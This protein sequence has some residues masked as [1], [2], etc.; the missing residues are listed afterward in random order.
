[1]SL[2]VGQLRGEL[3]PLD[4]EPLLILG[5]APE[6][7]VGLAELDVVSFVEPLESRDGDGDTP[8]LSDL[9]APLAD[10]EGAPLGHVDV[11]EQ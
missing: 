2:Q 10:G 5:L 6:A 8:L 11:A 3:H 7:L 9:L 4:L 1:M